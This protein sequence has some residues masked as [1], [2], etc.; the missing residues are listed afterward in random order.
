MWDEKDYTS[1]WIQG[2]CAI[3]LAIFAV[4]DAYFVLS[5]FGLFY[6]VAGVTLFIVSVRI[7]WRCFI[8]A[9]TGRGNINR[10]DY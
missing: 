6:L 4:G 7:C 9:V 5:N 8:Y 2:I 3:V 10:D 1:R